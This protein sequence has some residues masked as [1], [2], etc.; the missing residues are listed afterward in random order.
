MSKAVLH[1]LAPLGLL[2]RTQ[3]LGT[4]FGSTIMRWVVR[5]VTLCGFALW[6]AQSAAADER[7]ALVIGNGAYRNTAA[8]ANPVNDATAIAAALQRLDFTVTLVIDADKRATDD[9]L[10][11][12]ARSLRGAKVGLFY[13]AGHGLQVDGTNYLIPVDAKLAD[14]TDLEFEANDI[15]QI[16]RLMEKSS[17]VNLL[18]LDACRDNPMA[19]TLAT[20]MRTRSVALGR[21]LAVSEGAIGT[22]IVYATRPGS[23]AEDGLGPHS[24]FTDALLQHIETPGIEVRQMLSRVRDSVLRATNEKQQPWDHSSL[25]GDFYF[26]PAPAAAPAVPAE[27]KPESLVA[28][29]EALFWESIK[30]STSPKDFEAYLAQ[31]PDGVFAALARNRIEALAARTSAPVPSPSPDAAPELEIATLATI[32]PARAPETEHML[33]L[34]LQQRQEIQRALSLIGFDIK[35]VDGSFGPRTRHAIGEWQTT[36]G[37]AATGFLTAADHAALLSQAGPQ[38]AAWQKA[39][40]EAAQKRRLEEEKRQQELR[41][42][43]LAA[44]QSKTKYPSILEA[45]RAGDVVAVRAFI[46]SG[47]NVDQAA[48]TGST[49]LHYAARNGDEAMIAVLLDA[50]ANVNARD[51]YGMG[52]TPMDLARQNNH[53]RAMRMIAARGG[54]CAFDKKC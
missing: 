44:A 54:R 20:A 52:W 37:F 22:L 45:A 48:I 10:R 19:Q 12:F 47:A 32:D 50:G 27:P 41:A 42:E 25:R 17:A 2:G 49:A 16:L 21:G 23:V 13:Y 6:L 15:D 36:R 29:K 51:S 39:Q 30:D 46:S 5:A 34:S 43:Q 7:V 3:S 38:L 53:D 11:N 31:F 26:R 35:S 1:S 18:F 4:W 33:N 14:E 9:A 24:P 8:L 40:D 28:D